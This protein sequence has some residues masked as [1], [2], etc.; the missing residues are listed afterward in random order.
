MTLASKTTVI[1]AALAMLTAPAFGQT[2][3]PAPAAPAPDRGAEPS[4]AMS[5]QS[6]DAM[7]EMM[8]QMMTEMLEERMQEDRAP[9]AERRGPDRWHRDYRMGPPERGWEMGGRGGIPRGMH[10]A[11]MR[12]MFAIVDADGDG[13]LSQSEVQ[14][15]VGRIF[16]A[17]DEDGDGSVDMQEIRSFFHGGGA[18]DQE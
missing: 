4:P 7:R 6:Q 17:V 13:A 18:E 8:R 2:S 16:N 1:A 9:R 14:D 15:F 3:P 12:M 11:K 10:G 5:G